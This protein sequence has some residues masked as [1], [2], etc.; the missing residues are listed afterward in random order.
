MGEGWLTLVVTLWWLSFLT[1]IGLCLGSFLNVVIYRLPR[2]QSLSDPLWSACPRCG[3]RIRWYDNLPVLSFL[4]LGGRCRD[5]RGPISVRYMVI[6]LSMALLVLVLLD[7]FMI[8]RARTGLGVHLFNLTERL[9]YDW[10]ILAAHVILF[11]C[12]LSMSAIDL[13]HY[14][15]DVRFTAL[16][17]AA[18]FVLHTLWT[19]TYP[20]RDIPWPRPGDET[21]VVALLACVGLLLMWLHRSTAV[22]HLE[23]QLEL[24]SGDAEDTAAGPPPDRPFGVPTDDQL[25]NEA[26]VAEATAEPAERNAPQAA[27]AG[28]GWLLGTATALVFVALFASLVGVEAFAAPVPHVWRGVVPIALLFLMIV[29]QSCVVRVADQEIA[30]ALEEERSSARAMV[31]GELWGLVPAIALGV[32]GLWI[33]HGGGDLAGRIHGLL[34]AEF[35]IPGLASHRHWQPMLGLSTAAVGFVVGGALGWAVRIA[36][37]LLFGK[38]AFGTGDI[39][40]MAAAGCVAGW[41]VVVLGFVLTCGLALL[42]W[43]V[44]LPVKR[45]RTIPL[46]PWLALS[47]LIV[48][49]FQDAIVRWPMV[50]NAVAAFEMIQRS[51]SGG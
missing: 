46:G 2:D 43:V 37:T 23:A 11:A 38:E 33:V 45:T 6:E 44:T 32:L 42:G 22:A 26:P 21:A 14:W 49:V 3:S 51:W 15:V 12:L 1:A 24:R 47:F 20:G 5:C 10:P 17:A 50:H 35:A 40:L 41:P 19:P 25:A 30:E 13:E 31:L 39:H 4:R 28:G 16:A 36:F 18:G 9:V 48:V 8:G 7:A 34:H 27:P 29:Q